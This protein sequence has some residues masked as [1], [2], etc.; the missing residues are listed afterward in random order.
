MYILLYNYNSL[1]PSGTPVPLDHTI[2]VK[3]MEF[4]YCGLVQLDWGWGTYCIAAVYWQ[5][6]SLNLPMRMYVGVETAGDQYVVWVPLHVWNRCAL[7]KITCAIPYMHRH[8]HVGPAY[9]AN[10][11]GKRAWIYR[12]FKCIIPRAL[13]FKTV[14]GK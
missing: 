7:Q 12:S 8:M 14:L 6:T 5:Q 4:I 13:I 3:R 11:A 1:S 9:G 10:S 2:A